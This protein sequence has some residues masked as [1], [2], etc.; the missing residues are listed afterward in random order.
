M[1]LGITYYCW[2]N[3]NA[4]EEQFW[5][6]AVAK[7]I[8]G[9]AQIHARVDGKKVIM[10]EASIRRDLQFVDEGVDWLPNSTIIEQLAS[11]GNMGRFGK[12]FSRR[13]TPLFLTMVVQ[14]QLGEGSTMS[15][16]PYHTPTFLQSS[17]SQPEKTHKPRKPTRKVTKVPQPSDPIEHV[18]DEAIHKELGDSLVRAATSASSLEVVVVGAKKPCEIPL[19]K[20]ESSD[21]EESLGEVASKQERRIDDIDVNEDITLMNVQV[22]AEMFDANKDL[23]GEE[24]FVEQEVVADKEKI[25]EVTLAQALAE[26]KTSKPK[27]KGKAE[28]ELE[29]NIALI[30]TLDDVQAKIDADNQLAKRLQA[31]EQQELTDEEHATLF[32]QL[33]EK[34]RKYFAAKRAEEKRNKPLTQAQKRK[35]MCTYLKNMERYTLKQLKEFEFDK[36]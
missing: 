2:V 25:D 11:I 18:A 4:V 31:K 3:V 35:R 7:P 36:V 9:E 12:G 22:D 34:R 21:N 1:L 5:S 19:L 27:T 20:L 13:I 24:V 15:T 33:L 17:P 6:T 26:L 10:F 32:V 16:D 29:A 8:N 30:E 28:K 14:S 23:S